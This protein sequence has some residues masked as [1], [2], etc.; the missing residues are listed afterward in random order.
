MIMFEDVKAHLEGTVFTSR[1]NVGKRPNVLMD[2]VGPVILRW[3]EGNVS[4]SKD[5]AYSLLT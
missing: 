4:E 2:M 1:C 5:G 3:L